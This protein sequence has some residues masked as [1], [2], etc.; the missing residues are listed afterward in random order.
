MLDSTV[1][2]ETLTLERTI[3]NL[4]FFIPF[5]TEQ[6][7]GLKIYIDLCSAF[8]N[9]SNTYTEENKWIL[10]HTYELFNH[11]LNNSV[12]IQERKKQLIDENEALKKEN[13]LRNLYEKHLDFCK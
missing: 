11:Y 1:S 5:C 8:F 4:H 9:L 7:K 12:E 2:V 13:N 6:V 10:E 3:E